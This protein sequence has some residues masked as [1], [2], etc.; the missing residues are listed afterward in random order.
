MSLDLV[1]VSACVG[2]ACGWLLRRWIA[3]VRRRREGGCA[4]AC[5]CAREPGRR[6]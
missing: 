1:I 3:A 6:V 5:G 2:A 4:G